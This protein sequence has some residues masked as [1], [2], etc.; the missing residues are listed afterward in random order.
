M[1]LHYSA[2]LDTF[3]IRKLEDLKRLVKI[4]LYLLLLILYTTYDRQAAYRS[5]LQMNVDH[6]QYVQMGK[7][8]EGLFTI[9]LYT[10]V[11]VPECSLRPKWLPPSLFRK[12]VCRPRN[13]GGGG[14]HSLAGEWAG[15]ANSDDRRESL[16]LYTLWV[17]PID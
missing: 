7:S 8:V 2:R 10:R 11:R 6:P 15:G 14:Q 12:R 5:E 13:Q 1:Y 17:N 4:E 16:V 3:W 9:P